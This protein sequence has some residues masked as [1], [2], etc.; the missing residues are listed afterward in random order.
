MN[1]KVK[2]FIVKYGIKIWAI[3]LERLGN[4]SFRQNMRNQK[5]KEMTNIFFWLK[6]RKL[7]AFKFAFNS[8]KLICQL[9][10]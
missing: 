7:F 3:V 9:L 10:M 2:D 8:G 1:E 6:A 4:I 5:N